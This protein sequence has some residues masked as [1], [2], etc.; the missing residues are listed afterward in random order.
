MSLGLIERARAARLPSVFFVLDPWP[1]YGPRVDQWLGTWARLGPL[2]APGA[3]ITGLSTR[4][5]L[6][7]A[8]RF[9]F[10]SQA[11]RD[12][13]HAAGLADAE[14][15]VLTP[16]VERSFVDQRRETEAH[17][18]GWQLLYV[19][20]I[21]EQKGVE[22]A[23]ESLTYL[24]D[25]ARLR[26]VGEGDRPYLA[27]LELLASKLGV[28]DRIVVEGPFPRAELIELYRDADAVVFPVLWSEPWG[29]VPLEAM[30][31][32]RPVVATGRGGS[33]EYLRNGRNSLLFDAG[34]AG[35][36]AAALRDLADD[37]SLRG[38]LI[39]GGYETAA[40]HTEDAFNQRALE[41]MLSASRAPLLPR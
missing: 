4:V 41:E 30:A 25:E 23:V 10:C 1:L 16:G 26:I 6:S 17:P 20:R 3:R 35:G 2:S 7:D 28:A 33:G 27:K 22:T 8:G 24:P 13:M 14:S 40:E 19:G 18:W 29:L 31:L 12:E 37:S 39:S 9:V 36:L 38:R 11:L 34:D 5:A 21:V 15:T 32:G